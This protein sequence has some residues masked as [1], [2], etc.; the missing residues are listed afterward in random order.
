MKVSVSYLSSNYSFKETIKR[1]N[2]SNA[3]MLHVDVMDGLY[4]ENKT[5]SKK[6][7]KYLEKSSMKNM[8][9]HL[10]CLKPSKYLKFFKSSAFNI[11]YFHPS[12]EKNVEKFIKKIKS[13]NKKVGIAINPD[14]DFNDVTYLFK[15][16]DY[17]LIMSVSPGKGGQSFLKE[18]VNVID[19]INE[20]IKDFDLDIKIAIDGG[21]NDETVLYIERKNISYVVSGSFIC[22]S[23]DFQKQI[24][25]L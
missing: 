2:E 7:I 19:K 24:E 1:V 25:K 4:V 17:I 9:V 10:M 5:F 16:I 23:E 3:C 15:N 18:S 12:T 14:D 6:E 11:I 13:K 21:V 8:D 20:Y 22:K